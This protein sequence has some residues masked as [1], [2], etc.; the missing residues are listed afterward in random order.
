MKLQLEFL[1][2]ASELEKTWAVAFFMSRDVTYDPLTAKG[3]EC[4]YNAL[5]HGRL[6]ARI[7][8]DH[9]ATC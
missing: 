9:P 5:S 4:G 6:E 7:H 1:H 8:H 2:F 3:D